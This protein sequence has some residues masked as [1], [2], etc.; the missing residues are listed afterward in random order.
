MEGNHETLTDFV[1]WKKVGHLQVT[2][3]CQWERKA[4]EGFNLSGISTLTCTVIYSMLLSI[5]RLYCRRGIKVWV[6]QND[7]SWE[8][9]PDVCWQLYSNALLWEHWTKRHP[10][11]WIL[12]SLSSLA[13]ACWN[14]KSEKII[15]TSFWELLILRIE[16]S[17][18]NYWQKKKKKRH[19][20]FEYTDWKN[21]S[22]IPLF[23]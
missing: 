10:F 13:S 4:E 6:H 2:S 22:K 20:V 8:R 23:T 18:G 16:M 9:V 14:S 3:K 12:I 5:S 19:P 21:D 17:G 7:C 1:Q 11:L 15:L